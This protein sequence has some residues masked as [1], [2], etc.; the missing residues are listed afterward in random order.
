MT[1]EFDNRVSV[2]VH[3]PKGAQYG[4]A[5]YDFRRALKKLLEVE[6]HKQPEGALV[7]CSKS[8]VGSVMLTIETLK[9]YSFEDPKAITPPLRE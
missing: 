8:V 5:L 9:G 4:N 1:E 2:R 6:I 7:V 3:V